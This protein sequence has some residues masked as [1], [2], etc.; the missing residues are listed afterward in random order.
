[1][2]GVPIRRKAIDLPSPRIRTSNLLS[3]SHV[4]SVTRALENYKRP[5]DYL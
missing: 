1:L 4:S 5:L 2:I 3:E